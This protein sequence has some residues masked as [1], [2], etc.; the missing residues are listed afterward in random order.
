MAAQIRD[1]IERE[2]TLKEELKE[3]RQDLKAHIEATEFYRTILEHSTDIPDMDVNEK[4]AAAHAYKVTY[5]NFAP[6]KEPK[7]PK[8]TNEPRK[9]K[10]N[11]KK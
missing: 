6:P 7:A 9:S 2:M 8:E 3:L 10:K 1:L 5:E 11:N 4:T